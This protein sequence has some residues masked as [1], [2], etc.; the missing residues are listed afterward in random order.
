[1]THFFN[2]RHESLNDKVSLKKCFQLKRKKLGTTIK[3]IFGSL[4]SSM[5]FADY[6]KIFRRTRTNTKKSDFATS[7]KN[8]DKNGHF[9]AKSDK[10]EL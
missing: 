2:F 9:M 4:L 5:S 7:L 6:R 1:M 10:I 3:S 8:F